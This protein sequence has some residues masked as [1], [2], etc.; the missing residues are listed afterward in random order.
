VAT[1]LSVTLAPRSNTFMIDKVDSF[2][3]T[4][5]IMKVCK[6]AQ[7]NRIDCYEWRDAVFERD[8]F[9][10]QD[11]GSSGDAIL[12]H[13]HHIKCWDEYPELR[14]EISNG[15]TLCSSCHARLHG[16]QK[17][18]FMKDGVSLLKGR[19]LSKEHCK[20]LSEAHKGKKL[21]LEHREKLKGRTP[22]NKGTKGI[23]VSGMKGKTQSAEARKK[24]RDAKKGK[25]LSEAHKEAL[26]GRT[27]WMKGKRHTEESLKKMSDSLKGK[28]SWMKGKTHTEE[29]KKKMSESSKGKV[30]WNKGL[31][32]DVA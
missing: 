23:V 11:C 24:M 13:A 2:K 17:C 5:D 20:K 4:G 3:L 12:I 10:C 22:W 25:K 6:V 9:T 21:S 1:L 8:N 14:I 16:K 31:R 19:T 30:P 28:V 27:P 18:N 15:I 26:K 7:R 29:S 32:K